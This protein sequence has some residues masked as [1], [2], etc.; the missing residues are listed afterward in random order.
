MKV[1]GKRF[2]IVMFRDIDIFLKGFKL[3]DDLKKSSIF[4]EEFSKIPETE[5]VYIEIHHLVYMD[6]S[7]DLVDASDLN[8]SDIHSNFDYYLEHERIY[9]DGIVE[10]N[11]PA[12]EYIIEDY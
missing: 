8:L 6:G 10:L 5:P 4:C 2:S 1:G 3:P 9:V 11:V 12:E 7:K